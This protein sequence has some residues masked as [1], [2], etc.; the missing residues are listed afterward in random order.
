MQKK[1]P[2]RSQLHKIPVTKTALPKQT[3]TLRLQTQP[4]APLPVPLLLL[5][6]RQPNLQLT[7]LPALLP[8]RYPR[9]HRPHILPIPPKHNLTLFNLHRVGHVLIIE[10]YHEMC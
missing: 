8:L 3:P 4:A 7:G 10:R 9:V 1:F 6:Q 2:N 5:Q